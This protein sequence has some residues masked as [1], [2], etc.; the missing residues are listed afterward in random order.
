[1]T[2]ARRGGDWRERA[3]AA[4]AGRGED[5]GHAWGHVRHRLNCVIL[6][7]RAMGYLGSGRTCTE[8]GFALTPDGACIRCVRNSAREA[9]NR[10]VPKLVLGAAAAFGVLAL[11]C[12]SG[13]LAMTAH[14]RS[15]T[16]L[17]VTPVAATPVALDRRF[18]PGGAAQGLDNWDVATARPDTRQAVGGV[19]G[20]GHSRPLVHHGRPGLGQLGACGGTALGA[21]G[22]KRHHQPPNLDR[23]ETPHAVPAQGDPNSY[24]FPAYRY[25]DVHAVPIHQD[26]EVHAVRIHRDPDLHAIPIQREPVLRAPPMR[27]EPDVQISH[28]GSIAI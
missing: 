19:Q 14:A 6:D 18:T 12:A 7:V 17:A 21:G 24:P 16:G 15:L 27:R 4:G 10:Q 28:E 8:H 22:G 13:T 1:V 2:P 26:P 23:T 25:P 11:L 5:D 9:R 3:D 20:C